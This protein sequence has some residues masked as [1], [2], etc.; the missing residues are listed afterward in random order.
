MSY[1]CTLAED[2]TRESMLDAMKKRHSYAAT[3]NI[4]LDYRLRTDSGKEYIQGDIVD[5][6]SSGFKL[7]VKVI[8]TT[9]IRQ[10]DIIKNQEFLYNRQKLDKEVEL[11]FVDNKKSAGEDMYYVRVVQDDNNIAWSSPIWVTTR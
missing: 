11:E 5:A 10:I 6:G 4:I 9:G 8:G 3:D 1:A 7:H 2:F